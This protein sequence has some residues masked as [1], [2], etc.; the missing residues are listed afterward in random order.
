MIDTHSPNYKV[1]DIQECNDIVAPYKGKMIW[2]DG[3][4]GVIYCPYIPDCLKDIPPDKVREFIAKTGL[5]KKREDQ[6]DF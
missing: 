5:K 3:D 2:Q 6:N 1:Y 4:I